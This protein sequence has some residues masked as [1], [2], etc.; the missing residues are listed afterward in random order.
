VA[1]II[2]LIGTGGASAHFYDLDSVR[3]IVRGLRSTAAVVIR[4]QELDLYCLQLLMVLGDVTEYSLSVE[5]AF[6]LCHRPLQLS[7]EYPLVLMGL[8]RVTARKNV[9]RDFGGGQPVTSVGHG[10]QPH[11]HPT[12]PGSEFGLCSALLGF[13]NGIVLSPIRCQHQLFFFSVSSFSCCSSLWMPLV[14]V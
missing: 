2:G 14:I 10:S 11:S 8:Q 3:C 13:S 12:S 1:I 4:G 9:R 6:A 7:G 5:F